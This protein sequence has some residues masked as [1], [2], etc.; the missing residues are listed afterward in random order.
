MVG[1]FRYRFP[2][3]MKGFGVTSLGQT[4]RRSSDVIG[5]SRRSDGCGG[6][7]ELA[8]I[9]SGLRRITSRAEAID[10]PIEYSHSYDSSLMNWRLSRPISSH[11][12]S[13]PRA[14]FPSRW[15]VCSTKLTNFLK[16]TADIVQYYM[17]QRY[18][19]IE[20]SDN[21]IEVFGSLVRMQ[22]GKN[23]ISSEPRLSGSTEN[24]KAVPVFIMT[25]PALLPIHSVK[26][27]VSPA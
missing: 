26:R 11:H 19:Q 5:R 25:S 6:Y 23:R 14:F 22:Y 1:A 8:R 9:Q 4:S 12:L 13:F 10:P 24:A 20:F 27:Y 3:R 7:G 15:Q 17:S 18:V 16:M 21:E 2:F